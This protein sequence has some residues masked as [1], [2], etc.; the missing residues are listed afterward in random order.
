MCILRQ[1]RRGC[2]STCL[3]GGAEGQHRVAGRESQKCSPLCI[4]AVH[5]MPWVTRVAGGA[6]ARTGTERSG[7]EK[8][9]SW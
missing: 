8:R 1:Q 4:P 3:G 6:F 5:W 2:W 9:E 7:T